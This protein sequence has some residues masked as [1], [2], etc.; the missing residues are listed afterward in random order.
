MREIRLQ[1]ALD[2]LRRVFGLEVVVDLL[3][4]IGVRAK[5][6]AG[7]QVIALDGVVVLADR[8]FGGNQPDIADVVLRAGLMAAGDMNVEWRLDVDARLAP[9]ADLGSM[10]LGIGCRELAAGIA[11]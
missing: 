7:E 1:Q 4:D 11:G 3:P 5:T 6:S 2:R 10:K 9:V 8:H